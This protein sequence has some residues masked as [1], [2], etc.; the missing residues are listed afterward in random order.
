MRQ[1]IRCSRFAAAFVLGWGAASLPMPAHAVY[2]LQQTIPVPATSANPL[3]GAFTSYDI[4]FFDSTPTGGFDYIADRTNAAVDVIKGA[5]A[6]TPASFVGQIF[7]TGSNAFAGLAPPLP[8]GTSAL[9]GPDGIVVVDRTGQHQVWAGDAPVGGASNS[10][11]KGFDLSG[12]TGTGAT[13]PQTP[14][15]TVNT[16]G[17]RRVDEGSYDPAHNV[18]LFANNA[19]AAPNV[20]FATLVN[21]STG[22]I[23]GKLSTG[24]PGQL[25]A[26]GLEQSVWIGGTTQR[27]FQNVDTPA[28]GGTATPGGIAAIDPTANGGAGTVTH[29]YDFSTIAR[30]AGVPAITACG[31]TGL[32]HQGSLL[33]VNCGTPGPVIVLDPNA[34]GGNGQI[35]ATFSAVT[36]GD[37]LWCDQGTKR[38]FVTGLTN[39][40]DLNS[41]AIAVLDFSGATPTLL[42]VFPTSFGAHSVASDPLTGDVYVPFGGGPANPGSVCPDGCIAVFADVAAV[43]EPASSSLMLTAL[44]GLGLVSLFWRR[45]R[46]L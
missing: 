6:S 3:G 7:P 1:V 9:S 43:P 26:G 11:L 14:A 18:L 42:E 22:A 35:I 10:P 20:P 17:N 37:E 38:C 28:V 24:V 39:G 34:N 19:E 32:D 15:F 41:R 8:A 45:H 29:F 25:P 46:Q 40:S 33:V 23:L 27:F 44:A 30:A 2:V 5:T 31:P 21:A 4:S 36:G 12:F 13:L 16:G